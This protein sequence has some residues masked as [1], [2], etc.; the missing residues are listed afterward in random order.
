M[1]QGKSNLLKET[2][3]QVYRL[4]KEKKDIEKFTLSEHNMTF[5]NDIIPD[6]FVRANDMLI[7][8]VLCNL[9]KNSCFYD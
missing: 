3:E 9:I 4:N 8:N 6:T 7:Y 1:V 5:K 2:Q